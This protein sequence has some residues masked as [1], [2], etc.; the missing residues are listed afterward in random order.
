MVVKKLSEALKYYY[1]VR[2]DAEVVRVSLSTVLTPRSVFDA[3][4]PV[5]QHQQ[6][7]QN[8]TTF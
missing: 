4:A 8:I 5:H 3:Y 6:I 7:Y 2:P 1:F